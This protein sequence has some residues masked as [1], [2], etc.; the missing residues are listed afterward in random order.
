MTKGLD[1]NAWMQ[2]NLNPEKY[3]FSI[4]DI[5]FYVSWLRNTFSPGTT[6]KDYSDFVTPAVLSSPIKGVEIRIHKG[7]LNKPSNTPV[8]VADQVWEMYEN[9]GY[10]EFFWGTSTVAGTPL[11]GA[12]ITNDFKL[13]D[14]VY[15]IQEETD[16]SFSAIQMGQ[17]PID[18]IILMHR[19]IDLGGM[20]IHSCGGCI[21]GKGV[22]FPGV[23]GAG[24]ST[25]ARLIK[26]SPK[27]ELYSDDR[28][29]VR[30]HENSWRLYGTPWPGEEGIAVNSSH[31]LDAL[32]FLTQSSETCVRPLSVDQ[33]VQRLL[34]VS[35]VPWYDRERVN[36]YL[37]LCDQLLTEVPIYEL[38]FKPDVQVLDVL[39]ECTST[40]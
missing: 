32:I 17:F 25:L 31:T 2:N 36:K 18:Q 28:I 14:I 27:I 8:F 26:T 12:K 3:T 7:K 22:V 23:S 5:I 34:R 21:G 13:V 10:L 1:G 6:G 39:E 11:W 19:L 15:D 33:A 24:K 29:I 38:C 37:K 35:S 30:Q 16:R 4:G 40:L 20:I 9:N